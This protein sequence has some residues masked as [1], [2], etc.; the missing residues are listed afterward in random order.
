MRNAPRCSP[1]ASLLLLLLAAISVQVNAQAITSHTVHVSYSTPT[2]LSG[3]LTSCLDTSAP[4]CEGGIASAAAWVRWQEGLGNRHL[5]IPAFDRQSPFSQMHPLEWGVNRLVFDTLG[6]RVYACL[7]S[8]IITTRDIVAMTNGTARPLLANVDADATNLWHQWL[9]SYH[10]DPATGVAVIH[11]GV[12]TEFNALDGALTVA[13]TM[14][15]AR[16][17]PNTKI[18]AVL[19]GDNTPPRQFLAAVKRLVDGDQHR[20][21]TMPDV[22]LT[23]VETVAAP[24]VANG[25]HVSSV[26]ASATDVGHVAISYTYTAGVGGAI[27][28]VSLPLTATIAP[29]AS[30]AQDATYHAHVAFLASEA[31]KARDNDPVL[32][33]AN[34]SMPFARTGTLRMCK[35]GECP[36][37]NLFTDA[38]RDYVGS[39]VAF[40]NSGG[41]RGLG[42][43]VGPIRFS[44]VYAALPFANTMCYG[45]ASGTTLWQALNASLAWSTFEGED[46]ATGGHLVQVSGLRI[47]FNTRLNYSTGIGARLVSVHVLDRQTNRFEPLN[48]SHLYSYAADSY[49]CCCTP[50]GTLLQRKLF[51]GETYTVADTLVQ[52]AV[53]AYLRT[54]SPYAPR[55]DGRLVNNTA[56][57]LALVQ[58]FSARIVHTQLA[59][60]TNTYWVHSTRSCVECPSNHESPAGGARACTPITKDYTTTIIAVCIALPLLI[61]ILIVVVALMHQR[62]SAIE[63]KVRDVSCAPQTGRITIIFTDIQDS[64]KLWSTCPQ[65]MSIAL[66][67]HHRVI[68]GAMTRHGIYEVKNAGDNFMCATGSEDAAVAFAMDVQ[69]DLLHADYPAAINE[70][71]GAATEDELF[72]IEDDP[73]RDAARESEIWHGLR[74]RIGMHS[75]EPTVVFDEVIK[76]YDYYG[77]TVNIAARTEHIT[78]GGQVCMTAE[79]ANHVRDMSGVSARD[80]GTHDMKG[81]AQPVAVV[82]VLPPELDRRVFLNISEQGADDTT[83]NACLSDATDVGDA[84]ELQGMF[85]TAML[86]AFPPTDRSKLQRQLMRAWRVSSRDVA[87]EQQAARLAHRVNKAMTHEM[88]KAERSGIFVPPTP[89]ARAGP[90]RRMSVQLPRFL[91]RRISLAPAK[92]LAADAASVGSDPRSLCVVPTAANCDSDLVLSDS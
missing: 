36:I 75:G 4:T 6:I 44:D 34:A 43:P 27:S 90:D 15:A 78:F 71:Y 26:A 23:Y 22:L 38:Y 87:E 31:V 24:Y 85:V 88:R 37:G 3:D 11:V 52:T 7:P 83:S 60:P 66:D 63:D 62:Q 19:Y 1:A 30:A 92:Q 28:S 25:T 41:L 50:A 12:S 20:R 57:P 64:T 13:R 69:R 51:E 53:A 72:D 70:V 81:V 39:D 65:C 33:T 42:W 14:V 86:R 79:M 58:A 73:S 29:V 9:L 84:D 67:T 68:R 54:N 47:V 35:A 16:R 17:D 48:R 74:V 55:A 45:N 10:A 80:Y 77:P 32:S 76:G 59:C 8:V 2:L 21:M 61:V 40:A 49:L 18:V 82:E 46:T 5:F 91:E 56:V 89:R